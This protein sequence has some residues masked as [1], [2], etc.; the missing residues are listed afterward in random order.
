MVETVKDFAEKH[1]GRKC[2]FKYFDFLS[3]EGTYSGIIVGWYKS[4]HALWVLVEPDVN[5][6]EMSS[7][8]SKDTNFHWR[9]SAKTFLFV[10]MDKI[11]LGAKESNGTLKSWPH[12][13]NCGSPALFF[14]QFIEC[15]SII[16]KNYKKRYA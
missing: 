15:S 6:G 2:S 5:I 14:F 4:S 16:C 3:R 13:C 9:Q 10:D 7:K 1:T 8:V 11:T 12:T